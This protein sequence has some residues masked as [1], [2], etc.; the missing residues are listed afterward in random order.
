MRHRV[1]KTW[2]ASTWLSI[3]ACI[4]RSAVIVQRARERERCAKQMIIYYSVI[5]LLSQIFF[6]FVL[7]HRIHCTQMQSALSAHQTV[8]ML[9]CMNWDLNKNN[10]NTTE[11]E[12]CEFWQWF[13]IFLILWHYLLWCDNWN[14]S[15]G[16][17]E[18]TEPS[19]VELSW[20]DLCAVA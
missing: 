6:C 4:L 14:R 9:M 19:R 17:F 15:H 2:L 8:C 11:R 13:Y 18:W 12:K 10:N 3:I 20:V 1:E 5:F 16:S 7:Q